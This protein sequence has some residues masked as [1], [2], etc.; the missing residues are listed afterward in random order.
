MNYITKR[1]ALSLFVIIT[2]LIVG[3][4][5]VKCI[6][7]DSADPTYIELLESAPDRS[8]TYKG[9]TSRPEVDLSTGTVKMGI[10]LPVPQGREGVTPQINLVY[11]SSHKNGTLGFG[12][13]LNIG[14]ME[15]IQVD[16]RKT[17]PC[18]I[19]NCNRYIANGKEIVQISPDSNQYAAEIETGDFTKYSYEGGSWSAKT[20]DGRFYEY[21]N[22]VGT[23]QGGHVYVSKWSLKK[24]FDASRKYSMRIDYDAP[25]TNIDSIN[26]MEKN[27]NT[28]DYQNKIVFEYTDEMSPEPRPDMPITYTNCVRNKLTRLL[29]HLYVYIGSDQVL[30]YEFMYENNSVTN[31]TRLQKIVQHG[32]GI[33]SRIL[34]TFSWNTVDENPFTAA[35]IIQVL[36]SDYT[37]LDSMHT[38]PGDFNGDNKTDLVTYNQS[39]NIF[40]TFFSNGD[41]TFRVVTVNNEETGMNYD[42]V[43]IGDFNGDGKFDIFSFSPT[44]FKVFFSDGNGNYSGSEYTVPTTTPYEGKTV[45]W[46]LG[47]M[48]TG[49]FNGDG[50]TD[51]LSYNHAVITTFISNENGFG[52]FT[53]KMHDTSI[54]N[55]NYSWVSVGDYNGDGKSDFLTFAYDNFITYFSEGDGNYDM[56]IFPRPSTCAFYTGANWT[57]DYN[58]DG[59][60]DELCY[61]KNNGYK[62]FN[63]LSF[64]G[65]GE[66][67]SIYRGSDKYYQFD[68]I[69]R[70]LYE[71]DCNND[72]IS[73]VFIADLPGKK[74]WTVYSNSNGRYTLKDSYFDIGPPAGQQYK[75]GDFN[76]DGQPDHLVIDNYNNLEIRSYLS[77]DTNNFLK[78]VK[79]SNGGS[80]I[81]EYQNSSL[82]EFNNIYLPF[83]MKTVSTLTHSDG[84]HAPVAYTYKYSKGVYDKMRKKFRG[85]QFA[86]EAAP[87]SSRIVT[88]FHT[89]NNTLVGKPKKKSFYPS[90]NPNS[91]S[92]KVIYMDWEAKYLSNNRWF[93]KLESKSVSEINTNVK[94]SY[95]YNNIDG[96]VT[97]I[98]TTGTDI[99][100]SYKKLKYNNYSDYLIKMYEEE[101]FDENWILKR[102]TT[103]DYDS[104]GNLLWKENLYTEGSHNQRTS[105]TYDENNNLH[106]IEEPEGYITSTEGDYTTTINYDDVYHHYP[107]EIIKNSTNGISHITST[108]FSDYN[109]LAGKPEKIIDENEI[110]TIFEYDGYGRETSVY[111]MEGGYKNTAYH[112]KTT[113]S[114]ASV[115]TMINAGRPLPGETTIETNNLVS[116]VYYDGFGKKI[117]TVSPNYN[118]RDGEYEVMEFSYD[119][120]ERLSTEKG[121][122]VVQA[123]LTPSELFYGSTT[124]WPLPSSYPLKT[125]HYS[126]SNDL[127]EIRSSTS[128]HGTIVTA[129][130]H[131]SSKHR[132]ITDPDLSVNEIKHDALGRLVEV[133]EYGD[134]N[135]QFVTKY[136][137]SIFGDLLTVR[138]SINNTTTIRYDSLGRKIYMDDPDMGIWEYRYD[139][140]NNLTWQKDANEN[141]ITFNY[142]KLNRLT[143]KVHDTSGE[144]TVTYVYDKSPDTSINIPN[145]KGRLYSV[146]NKIGTDGTKT[147]Y[148]AYDSEGRVKK[149][150]Q[151]IDGDLFS[152]EYAYTLDG[153]VVDTKYPGANNFSIAIEPHNDSV[154][155][156]NVYRH[157]N[158]VIKALYATISEYVPGGKIHVI[159]TGNSTKSTYNYDPLSLRLV[160]YDNVA[161]VSGTNPLQEVVYQHNEYNY[162]KAGDISAV[163]DHVKN[164]TRYYN[165]DA[166]HRLVSETSSETPTGGS[167]SYMLHFY[168][169]EQAHG[170]SRINYNGVDYDNFIHDDNGSLTSMPDF[171]KA[172]TDGSVTDITLRELT[173]NDAN[174][175]VTIERDGDVIAT[176]KYDWEGRRVKKIEGNKTTIYVG[177]HYEVVKETG[178]PDKNIRYIF[179]GNLRIA[180]VTDDGSSGYNVAY[181]HKDHLGSTIVLNDEDAAT[182]EPVASYM[183]YGLER[184][185]GIQSSNVTYKFTDQELDHGTGLYNYD[186]RLYDP[187][188]GMFIT[189]DPLVPNFSDLENGH[190]FD[191]QMLNRYAYCRNNPLIYIDPSGLTVELIGNS[192]D[193]NKLLDLLSEDVGSELKANNGFVSD[194]FTRNDEFK[195]PQD[196]LSTLINSD[197]KFNI[198]FDDVFGKHLTPGLFREGAIMIDNIFKKDNQASFYFRS[199]PKH[200]WELIGPHH[201][202]KGETVIAHELF[203][204]GLSWENEGGPGNGK[205]LSRKERLF[206]EGKAIEKANVVRGLLGEPLRHGY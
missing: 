147:T 104:A 186:A 70:S 112:E 39:L 57:G 180:Q 81:I 206:W 19:G 43:R 49:D 151:D 98:T 164:I 161:P 50:R 199:K 144:P 127:D 8:N 10:N 92:Y 103:Y 111:N 60:A 36:P 136:T 156:K 85:F 80:T 94:K 72:G 14:P 28:E 9:V 157:D 174:M 76:G 90:S 125:Y 52:T 200:F 124:T 101:S 169:D 95:L 137:Y 150:T 148:D 115:S 193:Q 54:N 176:L 18:P 15:S 113:T 64:K 1:S 158:E 175:P 155:L 32:D 149:L 171:Y 162:T 29:K 58:G 195:L 182:V 120:N 154:M 46:A 183:P 47:Y 135:Q 121:P 128:E 42:R 129:I 89:N 132:K 201:Y 55:I 178:K 191:P 152:T 100:T 2:L 82:P 45:E 190:V 51:I 159:E 73:D 23:V 61:V 21:K 17:G 107:V 170:V 48:H 198:Q 141:E 16:T 133:I 165:Y 131:Y 7:L 108:P 116:R 188:I 163:T 96:T 93:A 33:P 79:N 189:P 40:T 187:V 142:D 109:L 167:A 41:G 5:T 185:P 114:L 86:T 30:V 91:N 192:E 71:G 53:I 22:P 118:S 184:E 166:M 12:W 138:D 205:G 123:G 202:Y 146:S 88:E 44:A 6:A 26:Y 84:V 153:R 119:E 102:K 196:W 20:K 197:K 25:V 130:T 75:Q 68:N 65:N 106:T 173:Y 117:R 139:L 168:E 134:D 140:N 34:Y 67:E 27:K 24:Q 126:S 62:S 83:V 11:S 97:Q 145:C 37:P 35:P 13:D 194:E 87:N 143:S 3:P 69:L 56:K 66:F 110:A 77:N 99:E 181:Y 122:F 31:Q 38:W 78:S 172:V 203:G 74:F 179:A 59:I 105:Y 204:H 4:T 63:T 177:E 160:D